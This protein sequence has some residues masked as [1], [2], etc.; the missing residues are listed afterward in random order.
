MRLLF[1]ILV[2]LNL[3]AF[4][5]IRFAENRAGAD[6]QLA[7]LQI[8]P[9][10][11]KLVKPG[12]PALPRTDTSRA[13]PALVCLEWGRFAPADSPRA[14]AALA[15]AGVADKVSQRETTDNA[16]P[17]SRATSI[18]FVIRDPGDAATEKIAALKAEFPAAQLRVTTCAEALTVKN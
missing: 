16:L 5:Y 1:L 14:G 17:G 6:N 10:K 13:Q 9:E 18:T 3:L 2:L 4:G 11:M 8:A 7:L 15:K 12:A